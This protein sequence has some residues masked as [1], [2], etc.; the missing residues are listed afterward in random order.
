MWDASSSFAANAYS[1]FW[2]LSGT[3]QRS[4]DSL[5]SPSSAISRSTVMV[6]RSNGESRGA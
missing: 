3:H 1:Q 2:T 4:K 5:K 6:T